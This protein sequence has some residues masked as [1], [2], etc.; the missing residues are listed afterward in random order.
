MTFLRNWENSFNL[1]IFFELSPSD[2][3]YFRHYFL[4]H[5]GAFRGA[6]LPTFIFGVPFPFTIVAPKIAF[7]RISFS[8]SSK[9]FYESKSLRIQK[10]WKLSK[11]IS[12]KLD[13]WSSL[14]FF[15]NSHERKSFIKGWFSH[16]KIWAQFW[17]KPLLKP[18]NTNKFSRS[19]NFWGPNTSLQHDIL[20]S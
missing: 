18:I 19:M 20:T 3:R 4:K 12:Q 6:S 11:H 2:Y 5:H 14:S 10:I 7:E 16:I 15:F 9:R 17:A 1:S 8:F 13:H